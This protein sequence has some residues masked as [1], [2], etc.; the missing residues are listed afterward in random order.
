MSTFVG[1]SPGSADPSPPAAG[2]VINEIAA[3]TDYSDPQHPEYDSNDWIELLNVSGAPVSL[4]GYYLSDDPDDL[5]KSP[6][7]AGVLGSGERVVYDEISGFHQPITSGFGIDKAG[8]QLLLS[9]L[10]GSG[11][12]R[13]VDSVRFKGQENDR[14]LGRWPDPAGPLRYPLLRTRGATNT[15]VLSSVVISELMYHPVDSSPTNDNT[16]HEFVELHNSLAVP[17]ALSD[18]N[19]AWRLDGGISYTFPPGVVLPPGGVLL[20]LEVD[21]SDPVALADFRSAYG[22]TNGSHQF[23]GPY[24]GALRNRGERVALEKPQFPDL[25]GDPYSWVVVDE[26]IYGNQT[27]WPSAANG[28]GQSL[29]RTVAASWGDDPASWQATTPSPGVFSSSLPDADRD[30]DGMPDAWE[31][32]NG[33]D[34]DDPS[35][36]VDD[37]DEDGM[38]NLDE[39]RSGTDPRSGASVLRVVSV[40]RAAEEVVLEVEVTAGRSY[41]V[42][43]TESL[44]SADWDAV[45]DLT[46]ASSSQL[47]EVR[48]PVPADAPTRHYRVVTPGRL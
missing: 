21:P 7:P 29:G 38:N 34:P 35:D 41:T 31:S 10:P 42:E 43:Q 13:V 47:V 19:G 46:P 18:T 4:A 30:E 22:L 15:A 24:D 32:Q 5:A 3:H 25:P 26:V 1:G 27:P 37:A 40:R 28:G 16:V 36:A 45:S 9:H 44:L 23:F 20:V 12:D 39:Y 8:E 48:I 6:L 11:A 17:V 14:S 2:L 33:L